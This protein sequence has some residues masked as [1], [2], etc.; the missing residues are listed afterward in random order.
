MLTKEALSSFQKRKF[1]NIA[2][3]DLK[4]RPNVAPKFLLK[5]DNNAIYLVDYVRNTTLKNIRINPKVSISFVN[6]ET[7]KG[8]QI[9]GEAEVIE[10]GDVY[11]KLVNEYQKKQI[12][13]STER[14]IKSL[15]D[16]NKRESFEAGLPSKK[17]AILKIK[18]NETVGIG[19]KG[20]LE[21]ESVE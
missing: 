14:L 13:D 9:N 7:L 11:E 4:N 5:I 1:L 8:F 10:K 19:L 17:V 12:K 3:C 16:K 6:T 20:D 21:R 18:I 2:T 15:H